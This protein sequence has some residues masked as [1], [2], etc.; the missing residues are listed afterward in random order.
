ASCLLDTGSARI[1]MRA[2]HTALPPLLAMQWREFTLFR[3]VADDPQSDISVQAR[4]APAPNSGYT[5]T[6]AIAAP[7]ISGKLS[8]SG[9]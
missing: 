4:I 2:L 8:A 5:L 9:D 7:G 3:A 1:A 6:A